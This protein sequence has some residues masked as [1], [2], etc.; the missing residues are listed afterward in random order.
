MPQKIKVL[1][2]DDSR[3]LRTVVAKILAEDPAV[4]VMEPAAN[5]VLA[6]AA[7]AR[8]LPDV[9]T[10]DVEMPEMDGL[11]TLK[12]IRKLHP[13]LPVIMFSSLTER[14]AS[15][16][17]N[18]LFAGATDYVAKPAG[19]NPAATYQLVRDSLLVKIKELGKVGRPGQSASSTRPS[20]G[21]ISLQPAKAAP[22]AARPVVVRPPSAA[23]F[24]V[25]LLAIGSSTGGPNALARVLAQLPPDFPVPV[26]IVQH[27][28]PTFT[29]Y[30]AERLALGCRLPVR[31]AQGKEELKAGNVWVA[32]G[33]F[34]MTLKRESTT[35]RIELSQGPAENFCRPSVDVLF[36]SVAETMGARSLGVVLTGMGEDG[37]RGSAL[38]TEKGGNVIV[39][40]EATSVVWG[41][42]GAV[43]KAGLAS[44][45]LPLEQIGAEILQRVASRT[46]GGKGPTPV[47]T[48]PIETKK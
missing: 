23:R 10:L 26:V 14:G 27:M 32:P 34:H 38:I 39:Q 37:L 3:M 45:V 7:I 17:M 25:E 35:L 47:D 31:E 43:A 15:V 11:Q 20:T 22:V 13:T 19:A 1:I 42:A 46:V 5:G 9:V 6:L 30:L 12:E 24:P 8:A 21:P 48:R 2:V 40:D 36:R 4:E 18:A 29:K 33:D 44:R 28:P 16:T 41:M